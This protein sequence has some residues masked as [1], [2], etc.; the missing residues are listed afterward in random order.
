MVGPDGGFLQIPAQLACLDRTERSDKTPRLW[1]MKAPPLG[2]RTSYPSLRHRP[3]KQLLHPPWAKGPSHPSLGQRPR[4]PA[5]T[6]PRA[7]SPPHQPN[8]STNPPIN[9]T[10]TPHHTPRRIYSKTP[11]T[12][13]ETSS[14]GDALPDD[15]CIGAMPPNP[16][17]P[18]KNRHN[19]VATKMM[20]GP[21]IAF[22]T[23]FDDAVFNSC[24]KSARATVRDNRMAR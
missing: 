19:P 12:R 2:Q 16:T 18:P 22:F 4:E 7:E 8:R 6:T 11:G 14:S 3:R 5:P 9:P 15:R 1:E 13:P 10:H 17:A 21:A 24:T 20:P 23:H